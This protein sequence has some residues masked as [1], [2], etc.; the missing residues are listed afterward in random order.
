MSLSSPSNPC[1]CRMPWKYKALLAAVSL[2]VFAAGGVIGSGITVMHFQSRAAQPAETPEAVCH[3]ITSRLTSSVAID[4]DEMEQIRAVVQ[5]NIGQ[6][7]R[8]RDEYSGEIRDQ[9]LE[10]CDRICE[11]LGPER[12]SACAHIFLMDGD[13]GPVTM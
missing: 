2:A 3:L 13:A 10:M 11:I 8:L 4:P 5:G 7:G 12:S 9:L 1:S 6:V